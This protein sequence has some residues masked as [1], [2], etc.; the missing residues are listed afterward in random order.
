M[1]DHW[2]TGAPGG[3]Y[4][5][6]D[7]LL[8][9]PISPYGLE[10]AGQSLAASLLRVFRE[11]VGIG[12]LHPRLMVVEAV[13]ALIPFAC[14]RVRAAL[15]RAA[16]FDIG[17]R[18]LFYG[19]ITLRGDANR[20]RNLHIGAGCRISTPCSLSLNAPI[21][22]GDGVVLGYGVTLVTG[23][24]DL[25]NPEHRAG[26]LRPLPITIGEGAWLAANVT[27]LPG[28]T[29]GPGAVV[30]AGSIV[31]RDVPA[32]TL[33]AGNPARIIRRLDD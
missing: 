14:G 12:N 9:N 23:Y 20:H 17:P 19:R 8:E 29:I 18:T 2:R 7:E 13:T 15:Y 3:E 16:G 33:M 28:V 21:T 30:G 22:L 31:T 6:S 1:L 32:H 10:H 25:S 5:L 27:V 4:T 24:H 11:E 26:P